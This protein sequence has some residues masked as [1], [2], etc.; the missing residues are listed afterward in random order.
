MQSD[1]V[2][3]EALEMAVQILT[4]SFP[5]RFKLDGR[6][7]L[8]IATGDAFDLSEAGRNPMDIVARLVQ[9]CTAWYFSFCV[10]Q[11]ACLPCL[12]QLAS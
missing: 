2:K 12:T 7:L 10:P 6:T 1:N 8:N 3:Q 11:S 5:D 9:V 4:E